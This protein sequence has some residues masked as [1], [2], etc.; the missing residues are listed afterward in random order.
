VASLKAAFDKGEA[1]AD[2][3]I[4]WSP[5]FEEDK[6]SAYVSKCD[7][8]Y[9]EHTGPRSFLKQYE[10]FAKVDGTEDVAMFAEPSDLKCKWFEKKKK[11]TCI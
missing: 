9:I 5:L 1:H 4:Q 11:K 2:A 3:N 6:L 8:S 10:L 7:P